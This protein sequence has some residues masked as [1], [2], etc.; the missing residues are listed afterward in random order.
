MKLDLERLA[1][2]HPLLP[3][4]TAQD[5]AHKAALAL[6]RRHVPGVAAQVTVMAESHRPTLHWRNRD[7]S[8]AQQLDQL[9][10]TEDGAEA[11]ALTLVNAMRGW[12]VLR[13]LQ[14]GEH[15]DWLLRDTMSRRLVALEVSGTD[16]GDG[17]ARLAAKLSQVS[18]TR[19]A[20]IRAACVVGFLEPHAA[21]ELVSEVS[22]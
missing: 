17:R 19:A 22:R 1:E 7:A 11:V 15:A 10:V 8:D 14:R 16:E 12:V 13:R 9:R 5:L 20:R 21:L 18:E 6:Q 3:A 4:P 2:A